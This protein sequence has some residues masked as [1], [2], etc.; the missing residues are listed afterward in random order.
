MAKILISTFIPIHPKSILEK[1]YHMDILRV[2]CSERNGFICSI[3][4]HEA[5][6]IL[7]ITKSI[8][9]ETDLSRIC[10]QSCLNIN[11]LQELKMTRKWRNNFCLVINKVACEAIF[12]KKHDNST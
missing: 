11:T 4:S 6:I 9:I 12:S 10:D 5:K 7:S 1:F 3:V 8:R 2:V